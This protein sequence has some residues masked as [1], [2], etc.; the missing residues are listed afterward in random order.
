MQMYSLI[1]YIIMSSSQ[2]AVGQIVEKNL[3]LSNTKFE[4]RLHST[5]V[6][7]KTNKNPSALY[8]NVALPQSFKDKFYKLPK[9][10]IF[11]LLSDTTTD[12]STNLLL[13]EKYDKDAFLFS[14]VIKSRKE[15][16]PIKRS[17]ITYW[18]QKLR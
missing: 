1:A 5:A 12:W 18:K 3:L 16:L 15:W 8:L 6:F 2:M 17:E 14:T 7:G 4:V 11:Q 10:T 13:Y 9:A